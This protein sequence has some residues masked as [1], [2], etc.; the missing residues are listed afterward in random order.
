MDDDLAENIRL[1][2]RLAREW[3]GLSQRGFADYVSER[4][5]SK[6][7]AATFNRIERGTRD[8]TVSELGSIARAVEGGMSAEDFMS[9]PAQFARKRNL[10]MMTRDTWMAVARIAVG[11]DSLYELLDALD[12]EFPQY[13]DAVIDALN[14]V[15]RELTDELRP[16]LDSW[17]KR[18]YAALDQRDLERMSKA[19][20]PSL[21]SA[22]EDL[23][24]VRHPDQDDQPGGEIQV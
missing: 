24:R 23:G 5:G 21:G 10:V 14:P 22:A 18:W 4:S 2:I 6:L 1:N 19:R 8:V 9:P 13:K 17:V 7:S 16:E 12:D 20:H 15:G 11:L 3:T